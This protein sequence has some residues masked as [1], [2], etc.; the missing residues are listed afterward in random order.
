M[1]FSPPLLLPVA[2]LA[3][4]LACGGMHAESVEE[5]VGRAN[6]LDRKL[7]AAEALELYSQVEK[8]QPKNVAILVCVARQYRHLMADAASTEEKR[9]L[10]DLA[11]AYGERAVALA[12]EDS[13]AQLSVAITLGKM[14]PLES[15]K[16][17]VEGSRRIRVAVDRAIALD[18]NNDL[19]WHVLGRWHEKFADLSAIRR[20]MGELLY[21]KLPVSTNE[22][23]AQCFLKALQAN[24]RRL[25]H[26]IELGIVYAK[27]GRAVEARE[28][29][30]KGLKMPNVGKDDPDYKR[31]GKEALKELR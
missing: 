3:F 21:G 20:G 30:E 10:G 5:L 11:L 14:N 1:K 28:L 26:Y 31:R 2:I 4:A 9:R 12:P 8:V 19:A 15:P 29:I 24:P 18:P 23:A 22:E 16:E 6:V 13:E 17:Q 27:I 25:M 7:R